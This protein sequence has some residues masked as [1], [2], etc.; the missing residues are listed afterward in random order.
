MSALPSTWNTQVG[1][2][3]PPAVQKLVIEY[4]KR[5][6]GRKCVHLALKARIDALDSEIMGNTPPQDLMNAA[7]KRFPNNETQAKAFA[8]IL[9]QS[10]KEAMTIKMEKAKADMT[11]LYGEL[12]LITGQSLLSLNVNPTT[13]AQLVSGFFQHHM[14]MFVVQSR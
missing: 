10:N 14:N 7:S 1:D 6:A 4:S 5:S 12:I 9:A 13:S 8:I 11:S 2:K 3:L